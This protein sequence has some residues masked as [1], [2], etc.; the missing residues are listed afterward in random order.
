MVPSITTQ[1][2][3]QTVT[4]GANVSFTVAASGTAPLSYQWRLNGGNIGG[5]TSATL[6][7][8][9]V[10]TG[11]TGS[12]SCVVSNGAGSATSSAAVLTVNAAAVVPSITTQ[13]ASQTVTAGA[14]VSFTVA[15]SG[16][17]PL[18][19]QWRLNG[20]NIGGATSATLTLTSVT[21]GQTGSYSC[22]VSNGAGS[23]TSSAAVLTVNA[24]AVVPSITTQPASQTVT[25]GA[26]VSF[27]VAASGTAPL[28]YQWRLNGGN[29]GGAAS[30]TLTLTSVTT[31]HAGAYTCVVTNIAGSVTSSGAI[32]TVQPGALQATT[33]TLIVQGQGTVT[34]NLNAASLTLGQAYTVTATPASGY[35]FAGWSGN[36]PAVQSSS[37][38]LTFVMASNLVLQASF[39]P[40]P[41]TAGA[42]TYNG[43][44]FENDEVH[45]ASAGA[46]K[47]ASD[48][49]GNYSGWVQLGYARYAFTGKLDL[50]LRATNV[51]TRWN[52]PPLTVELLLGQGNQAGQASGRV[53]DGVWNSPLSGGRATG[54]SRYAGRYTLII[55]GLVGDTL[56]PAGDGY[57]TLSV[58]VD[59]L[60]IMN[61]TLSDGTQFMQSAFVTDDG[62]WPVYVSLYSA[63]GA[64]VS[65]MSF[66]DLSGS[67]V[68]GSLVWIKQAGAS[69][70]SYSAGFTNETKAVGSFYVAPTGAGKVLNL[71]GAE[72]NFSG[73]ELAAN[74]SNLVSV[75]AGSS[76]VN[77]SP[78]A[79]TLTISPTLG[80]FTGQ[81]QKP[82]T[83]MKHNFG[84]VVLQK[85]N[86]GSGF[87]TGIN[88]S[89]RVV[90][91]AP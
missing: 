36:T 46:F 73:G 66:A 44:F 15:A 47:V 20:G 75:N 62:S 21:T 3:S 55:P 59:G 32:L 49:G 11:Q 6:T 34:P 80:S 48:R 76:V 17:A 63:R 83:S 70:V 51:I 8:T 40:T 64:V 7:L 68:S 45:L 60:G 42:G 77:L 9:S 65:W 69:A 82:G 50:N 74:F 91:A 67:D 16:T 88:A 24:A 13:P 37:A 26:N 30:A 78:N 4:A 2:A 19:Y 28:S 12:Y 10:T 23:A 86:V 81:V 22:V 72:V 71:S 89:S 38:R 29:I 41:Y 33:L 31:N 56:I 87:M 54:N 27:T 25:A 39:V 79:L 57:A 85:Q 53:T 43:L 35:E 84:G 58:G 5:A 18:S 90:I 52:A 61:G 14:N 1:P